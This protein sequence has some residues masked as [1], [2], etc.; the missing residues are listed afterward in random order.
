MPLDDS[1]DEFGR[2]ERTESASWDMVGCSHLAKMS[3]Y[4]VSCSR[5][6]EA[7]PMAGLSKA[8]EMARILQRSGVI[9]GTRGL[10]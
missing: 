10:V 4:A 6:A 3:H 5:L 2:Y 7:G 1:D 9:V 8:N